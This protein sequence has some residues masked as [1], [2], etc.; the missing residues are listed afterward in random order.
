MRLLGWSRFRARLSGVAHRSSQEE[1][2][3]SRFIL[4]I[5]ESSNGKTGEAHLDLEFWGP[6]VQKPSTLTWLRRFFLGVTSV[7]FS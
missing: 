4:D 7:G 5:R 3:W 2:K 6:D 1:Q